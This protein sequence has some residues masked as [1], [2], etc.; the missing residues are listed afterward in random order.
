MH[1]VGELGGSQLSKAS[2]LAAGELSSIS[3]WDASLRP[4]FFSSRW[5][6]VSCAGACNSSQP[7]LMRK[8]PSGRS[9]H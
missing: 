2:R 6:S 8:L 4:R 9:A 7:R 5:F 3:E 1:L